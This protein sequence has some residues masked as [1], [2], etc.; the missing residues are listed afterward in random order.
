MKT[1]NKEHS[2]EHLNLVLRAIR[3]ANHAIFR[4]KDTSRLLKEC[5]DNLVYNGGYHNAW[6]ALID[7]SGGLLTTAEAGLGAQFLPLVE[8]LKNGE[9]MDC[10][11][12]ALSRPGIAVT[13]NPAHTCTNCPLSHSYGDREAITVRLEHGEKVYGLLSASLPKYLASDKEEQTLFQDV[14]GDIALALRSL[15]LEEERE[16]AARALRESEDKYRTIFETTGTATV[17]IEEDTTISLANRK[18][19]KLSGYTQEEVEGKKSWTDFVADKADLDRM[20]AYHTA[21]RIDPNGA[22]RNYEY[23]F[24]DKNGT[25]KEIF[26][27]LAVIPGT[28]KS[29]GSFLD[30]TERK[31]TEE[32]LRESEQR[33][34]DLVQNSLTGIFIIRGDRIV[35]MNPEQERLFGPLPRSFKLADYKVIHTDDAE[36]VMHNYQKILSGETR[37]IDMD[38]R[39]YLPG[40]MESKLDMKWVHCRAS[41]IEYQ[42][43]EA[44]LVN[45][46]DITRA[47]EMEHLLRMQDKMTSLGRIAAGIAHEIRN[48]LSGINIYLNTLEKIYDSAESL[49]KVKKILGQVQSASNKIES[50]I[51][52]VMDFS[53]PS[54][55]KLMLTD[56]NQ[57]VEEAI[58][59]SSVTLRKSGINIEKDLAKDLPSCHV[60]PLLIEEVI[61]NLITNATEAMKNMDGDK[62]LGVSSSM[63]KNSVLVRVSDSGP[64]VRPDIKGK[65]FDPFYTTKN[66]STGIGL[67]L[68]H[69]I[70]SDHGGT[71]RIFTSKWG[72]AEFV[73]EIPIKKPSG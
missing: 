61:L 32:A 5:C 11:R 22:P 9:L 41:T 45:M 66:G 73:V 28:K 68:S 35:Y 54:E 10:G 6:I 58:N 50:V 70:I 34:R 21:R 49:G 3:N 65:I 4:E 44:V 26:A 36:K 30:I 29:V 7:D 42:G 23:K 8:L 60:D 37:T 64:G 20:M 39:L 13:K 38:F 48:P 53:K 19:A 69:R 31:R 72:G 47:K 51:R 24:I 57:P 71:L 63:E 55:P 17:I 43:T 25:V 59:L 33:L 40:K 62:I 1:K 56:I 18:F 15:E 2:I 46:M 67:S 52:R 27:T 16:H 14:A 12:R